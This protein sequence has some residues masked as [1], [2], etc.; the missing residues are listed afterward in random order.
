MT[1][2]GTIIGFSDNNPLSV[3]AN[4][5]IRTE[6]GEEIK[7]PCDLRFTHRALMDS[8][9]ESSAIGKKIEFTRDSVGVLSWFSP[10]EGR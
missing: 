10:L 7:V 6:N 2:T 1:E 8:F 9:G 3:I 4:L 5:V